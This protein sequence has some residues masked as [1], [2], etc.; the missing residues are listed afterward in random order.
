MPATLVSHDSC[1]AVI[2]TCTTTGS[3][4]ITIGNCSAYATEVICKA[5]KTTQIGDTCIWD[6]NACRAKK[7]TDAP[8][9]TTT[10][11]GCDTYLTGCKTNGTSC[12]A[13]VTCS[14]LLTASACQVDGLNKPCLFV[15]SVCYSY[16][17]C[18]DAVM[19]THSAC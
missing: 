14:T 19:T 6:T 1:K 17:K 12:V 13:S 4:C 18:D 3:G 5:A 7:C 11:A 8:T 10:D 9:G 15:N 16:A 2:S